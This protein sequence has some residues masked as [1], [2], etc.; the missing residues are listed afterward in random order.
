MDIVIDWIKEWVILLIILT[1]ILFLVLRVLKSFKMQAQI[2][3]ALNQSK[4]PM[5]HKELVEAT[6]LKNEDVE[7]VC[8]HMKDSGRILT[9]EILSQRMGTLPSYKYEISQGGKDFLKRL[10]K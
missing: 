2:L 3:K 8:R 1:L 7:R 9:K 4:V 5:G 10:I 6:G